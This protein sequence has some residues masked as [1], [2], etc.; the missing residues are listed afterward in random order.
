MPHMDAETGKPVLRNPFKDRMMRMEYEAAIRAYDV[1]HKSLFLSNGDR[2]TVGHYGS[3]FATYFWKGYDGVIPG[4]GR[5][6]AASKR[7]IAY[8]LWCAGRDVKQRDAR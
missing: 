5:W 7:M 6:D 8:A 3:A 4:N 2:R 1:K